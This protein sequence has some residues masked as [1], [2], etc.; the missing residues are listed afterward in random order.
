[1]EMSNSE[2]V[3]TLH[4][5]L[6]CHCLFKHWLMFKCLQCHCL[7]KHWLMCLQMLHYLQEFSHKMISRTHDIQEQMNGLV[8]EAKVSG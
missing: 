8:H 6:Q 3:I 4:L 5:G 2:L 1:M 7:F